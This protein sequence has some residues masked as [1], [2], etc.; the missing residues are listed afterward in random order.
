M[1]RLF[2]E[3]GNALVLPALDKPLCKPL[4]ASFLFYH[5]IAVTMDTVSVPSN[6]VVFTHHP[7][8]TKHVLCNSNNIWHQTPTLPPITHIAPNTPALPPNTHIAPN[9]RI[10]AKHPHCRKPT[11]ASTC[12]Y[13]PTH[14]HA[15]THPHIHMPLHT[16]TS[17]CPYTPTH[18]IVSS[19]SPLQYVCTGGSVYRLLLQSSKVS[20][21]TNSAHLPFSHVL[22]PHS[23]RALTA[24]C[25]PS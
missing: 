23:M 15:P 22:Y 4:P 13:T 8:S 17:T 24:Q 1:C 5:T 6:V 19:S 14:P 7:H 3:G 25:Y 11:L 9:T 10:A 2:K 21:T 18:P 16:H 12:P 20:L